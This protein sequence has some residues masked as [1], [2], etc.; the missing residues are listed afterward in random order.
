MSAPI[1]IT[2]ENYVS[3]NQFKFSFPRTV[4]LNEYECGLSTSYIY[5]SWYNI[6]AKF[7]NNKFTLTVPTS[8][9]PAT[10]NITIPNGAYNISDLNNYLQYFLIENGLYITNDTT[11]ENTYYCAFAL[12]QT[13]YAVQ[14]ITT[15]LPTSLPTGYT[16]GSMTF[17]AS[18]SKSY[19][20][21]ILSTNDFKDIIG[22]TAG[23]YPSSSTISGST[24]TKESDVAPNVNPISAV[25]VRLSCLYNPLSS[26]TQLLTVFTNTVPFG[27]LI[28]ISNNETDYV[29]CQG[30]Q[31]E[32]VLSLYD[33]LGRPL[34]L[35]DKNLVIKLLFRKK[36]L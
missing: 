27:A 1:L 7:N 24:Y 3:S 2:S 28:P 33:Q 12:S 36:K 5:Y 26:N 9:T 30:V 21:T 6:S 32:V 19:Q 25:Q 20:I 34:E 4:D 35:L 16:S 22:F 23:Q 29:Q 17:P 14:F 18:P 11:G 8:T 31:K 13:A 15:A 10:Y